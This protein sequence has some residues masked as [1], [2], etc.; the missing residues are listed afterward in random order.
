MVLMTVT[1]GLETKNMLVD[2]GDKNHVAPARSRGHLCANLLHGLV[3]VV[4]LSTCKA[5]C[6]P[7]HPG[8]FLV[9]TSSNHQSKLCTNQ[10]SQAWSLRIPA[11]RQPVSYL[12]LYIVNIYCQFLLPTRSQR[13]SIIF[14]FPSRFLALIC[15]SLF[16]NAAFLPSSS[17]MVSSSRA[18]LSVGV[19]SL[20]ASAFCR[21]YNDSAT[22]YKSR[23]RKGR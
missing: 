8:R 23:V 5:G 2:E 15:A 17:L 9:Y 14:S 21:V 12:P 6:P 4:V 7:Q 10:P 18:S 1:E 13:L 3:S 22:I 20:R 16:S 19:A 11:G